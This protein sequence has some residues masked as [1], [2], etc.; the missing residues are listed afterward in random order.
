MKRIIKGLSLFILVVLS[1]TIIYPTNTNALSQQT[2]YININDTTKSLTVG[3]LSFSNITF[4]DYSST[5]TLSFGL[6]GV[7]ANSSGKTID[8]TSTAYYYDS[9][10]KF[11]TSGE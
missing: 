1:L 6:T 8:Y 7:V 5:S 10:Y 4:K 2:S 3:N 9:N 11:I